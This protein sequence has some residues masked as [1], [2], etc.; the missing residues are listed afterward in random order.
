MYTY[1]YVC[2]YMYFVLECV[3]S[4]VVVCWNKYSLAFSFAYL[5]TFASTHSLTW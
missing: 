1:I 5:R 4:N 2:T 3:D